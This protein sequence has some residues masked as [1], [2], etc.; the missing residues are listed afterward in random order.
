MK[1]TIIKV[2]LSSFFCLLLLFACTTTK[3]VKQ[4]DEKVIEA[5]AE[6]AK[7]QV[8]T[9]EQKETLD[10]FEQILEIYEN[11]E[12]RQAA[13]KEAEVLYARIINEHPSTPL[14][15]ESYW[16]LITMFIRDYSPPDFEKAE[17]YYDEFKVKYPR[18]VL[19]NAVDQT[20]INGYAK[21]SEWER[22]LKFCTPAFTEYKNNGK[23][24]SPLMAYMYSEANY[25][26]GNIEE[27]EEGFRIA[28]ELY[29][30]L[31]YGKMA[32]KRLE[33]IKRKTD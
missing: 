23:E 31:G 26:L 5:P 22:L 20:I 28:A 30:G 7:P 1:R 14:A 32:K 33:E 2:I 9:K 15:Q 29:P 4:A 19:K 25:R 16:K 10:I 18:S 17:S 8:Y 27:A 12:S 11:A 13:A 21:H 6:V 3:G 24:P